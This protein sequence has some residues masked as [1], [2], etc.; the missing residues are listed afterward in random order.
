MPNRF[1]N[2]MYGRYGNDQLNRAISVVALIIIIV[3]II[4]RF[5]LL[6]VI[7][8]L[9]LLI[10]YLRM[11]SRNISKRAAENQLYLKLTARLRNGRMEGLFNRFGG[12]GQW[13]GRDPYQRGG[14]QNGCGQSSYQQDIYQK[15][16]TTSAR[17]QSAQ[18]RKMEREQKKIYRFF[19]CPSCSQK[20]RVPRGKGRIEITCPKCR[21][22]FIKKS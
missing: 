18:R 16:R 22:A 7:A 21:T 1:Q 17:Q 6:T 5:R 15:S 20:V 11:F 3:N 4:V 9:L 13:N 14:Y 2:F 19:V 8:L 10:M 12:Y